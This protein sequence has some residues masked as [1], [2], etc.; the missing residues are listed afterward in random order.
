MVRKKEKKKERE[1]MIYLEEL[2]KKVFQVVQKNKE[3]Q[4]VI[5]CLKKENESLVAKTQHLE[6][7]VMR[8]TASLQTLEQEK[9]TMKSSIESL[10]SMLSS[11]ENVQ[12]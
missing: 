1:I 4:E 7:A 2:E 3:L 12:Q 9:C 5:E 6:D 11:F 8:D 10:L